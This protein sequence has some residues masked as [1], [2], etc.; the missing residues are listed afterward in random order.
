LV[1][2]SINHLDETFEFQQSGKT[3]RMELFLYR[4][5]KTVLLATVGKWQRRTSNQKEIPAT[6]PGPNNIEEISYSNQP[7]KFPRGIG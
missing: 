3:S 5:G 1:K 7:R 4:Q 6:L 2:S